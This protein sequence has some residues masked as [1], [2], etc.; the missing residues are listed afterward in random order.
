MKKVDL[1]KFRCTP[2]FKARV[3]REATYRGVTISEFVEAAIENELRPAQSVTGGYVAPPAWASQPVAGAPAPITDLLDED[4][5][6]VMREDAEPGLQHFIT[7]NVTEVGPPLSKELLLESFE[8]VVKP[9]GNALVGAQ[10]P[11]GRPP[12]A[13]WECA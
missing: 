8:L 4:D 13:C 1:I 11:H 12:A 3:A 2:E 6:A 10:C 7:T 5:L 9:A